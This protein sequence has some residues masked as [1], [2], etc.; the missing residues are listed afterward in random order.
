MRKSPWKFSQRPEDGALHMAAVRNFLATMRSGWG[1]CDRASFFF[2]PLKSLQFLKTFFLDVTHM[3]VARDLLTS[4]NIFN[5]IVF[6][7][8]FS[9]I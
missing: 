1:C 8:F 4:S 7:F 3:F 2:T 6:S 5:Q 9:P